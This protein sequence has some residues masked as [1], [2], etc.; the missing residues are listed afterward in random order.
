LPLSRRQGKN[1]ANRGKGAAGPSQPV[2]YN[3]VES[4]GGFRPPLAT[5]PLIINGNRSLWQVFCLRLNGESTG[6]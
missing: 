4:A 1:C 2:Y 6:F 5:K 3:T